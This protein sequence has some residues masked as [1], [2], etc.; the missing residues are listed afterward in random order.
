[1]RRS[2]CGA[3]R[4]ARD[5]HGARVRA[6]PTG[7][8]LTAASAAASTAPRGPRTTCRATRTPS[9]SAPTRAS[10]TAAR[11]CASASTSSRA[12]TA[13]CACGAPLAPAHLTSPCAAQHVPQQRLQRPRPLPLHERPVDADGLLRVGRQDGPGVPLRRR[14]ARRGLLPAPLRVRQRPADDVRRRRPGFAHPAYHGAVFDYQH[15]HR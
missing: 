1:M 8:A 2:C 6:G 12:P 7:W 5:R 13:R 10:A 15:D 9:P 4:R 14:L 11:A 3:A